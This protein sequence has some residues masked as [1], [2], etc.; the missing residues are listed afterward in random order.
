MKNKT[1][2]NAL[3]RERHSEF[4]NCQKRINSNNLIY[5][6]ETEGMSPK[7]FSNYQNQIDLFKNLRDDNINPK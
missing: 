6:Y 2:F 1:I 5:K 7:Y 4:H 3:I